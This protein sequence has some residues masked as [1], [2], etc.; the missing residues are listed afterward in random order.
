[1]SMTAAKLLESALD[2][3][4]Q[5]DDIVTEQTPVT[6]ADEAPADS[7]EG[8]DQPQTGDAETEVEGAPI[9]SKSG[10]YTIPFEKLAEAREGRKAAL[11]RVAALEQ[12]IADLTAQQQNNLAIA[13]GQAQSRADAGLAPTA[14]DANLAAAEQAIDSGVDLAVF[15]D[16][17]EEAIAKGVAELNRRAVLQ[18]EQ[19]VEQRLMAEIDNRL[20]PIKAQEAKAA[21]SAHYD[22]IYGAHPD[23]DEIVESSE[24]A[25]WRNALPAFAQAGVDHALTKGSSQ[26]VIEVF[27]SF[28]ETTKPQQPNTAR[29]APEAPERRVPNSLSDVP[30]AAPMDETQ[31]TLAAAGNAA[32]L[33]ERMGAMSSDR[34]DDLL[35]NL[36]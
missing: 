26:D 13:Q 4:L 15:G 7:A 11:E 29:T 1:M 6:E 9:L 30:G 31:Q 33:L 8:Q 28:R 18:A 36:I 27:N 24:F 32:A 2:G 21:S 16:F 20:A 5:E 23:A 10:A 34:I 35:D 12:Q 25:A 17:S 22:A 3:T 14:A 19:R